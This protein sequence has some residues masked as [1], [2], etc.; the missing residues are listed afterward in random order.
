[1][2]HEQLEMEFARLLAQRNDQRKNW[3]LFGYVSIGLSLAIFFA[4]TIKVFMTGADP[5]P[6][7]VLIQVVFVIVGAA[8]L[9]AGRGYTLPW[10][11]PR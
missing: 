3:R 9:T 2:T 6:P 5:A 1:V 7:M 10:P 11:R 8:F 4:N